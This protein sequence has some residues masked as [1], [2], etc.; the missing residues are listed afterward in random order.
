MTRSLEEG[1]ALHKL[2]KL[3]EAK[4]IYE[5]ILKKSSNN[6]EA[7]NLLGIISLQL[8]DYYQAIKLIEK[9]ININPHH[10]SL[11]NNLGAVYKELREYPNAIKNY[12]KAI[13]LNNSYAEAY[14]NLGVVLKQTNQYEEAYKNYK[15][16]IELK[17]NYPEAYNNLGNL[18]VAMIKYKDA[19]KNYKKAIELNNSYAEAYNNLGVALQQTNQYEEAYKNYTKANILDPNNPKIYNNIGLLYKGLKLHDEAILNFNKA[20]ELEKNYY[21]AY[22]NRADTYYLHAKYLLA[23]QDW[24]KLIELNPKD[25]ILYESSIFTIKNIIC[26]W[27]EYKNDILKF[28]DRLL[29]R[30]L[31]TDPMHALRCIDSL[32]I[33]KINTLDNSNI[34]T[35]IYNLNN[36]SIKNLKYKNK[37]IKIA[38]YSGDFRKHPVGHLIADLLE[39]HNKEDFE[40]IGFY[41]DKYPDDEVTKRIKVTFDKFY[42]TKNV[43]DE[44]IILKSRELQ[45]DIAIDLMGYT[46][47]YRKNIFI[48]QSAPLQ[49]N[50]LGYPGTTAHNLDYIIADKYLIPKENQKYYFEKIIYMPDCYQPS[51]S[52]RPKY[53]EK[54]TNEEFNYSKFNFKFC[55]LNDS[56]KINPLI[57]NSWM[58]IL[59]KTKNSTLFLLEANKYC[60]D[61]LINEFYKENISSERL[62]FLPKLPYQEHLIRFRSFDLFLDT[63]PYSAHTTANEALW[64][65]VPLI[66]LSGQSFQSRVSSSLLHHL[67]MDSLITYNIKDYKDLAIF[68]AN[69]PLKF[70]E[71]KTKLINAIS[72][73]NVFDTKIY[74]SNLEKAYKAIYEKHQSD[75]DPQDIYLN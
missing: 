59:K 3:K 51:D 8:K 43:S 41:F 52:K 67:T 56:S 61:N 54:N 74:T 25:R 60:K 73:S 23:I 38:Y 1:I 14:N 44:D 63:F 11:Y 47:N 2:G 34:G 22:I 70:K 7:I 9:A 75:L 57:F 49:I 64:S 62:I 71:I 30:K 18:Y 24:E 28:E 68:L 72:T 15:K 40:V 17:K 20:I 50:Y 42:Y 29:E 4:I 5:E 48:N 31:N 55:C 45:V 35:T 66:S 53:E 26:D 37:K 16:S 33:I 36:S 39:T 46:N 12:K 13:E 32:N 69:N 19:I 27:K 6:F 10:H 21:E 65:G 58:Q